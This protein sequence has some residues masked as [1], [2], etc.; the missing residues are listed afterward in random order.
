MTP[1]DSKTRES[2]VVSLVRGLGAA[3]KSRALYPDKH[4]QVQTPLHRV[5]DDLAV[6]FGGDR[7]ELALAISDG[8]LVFEGVP[9]FTLTSSVEALMDR[10]QKIEA[11]IVIFQRGLGA[12]DLEGFIRFLHESKSG[13]EGGGGAQAVLEASGVRYIRV[14]P[15]E[16][17][18]DDDLEAARELYDGAVD[19][20]KS[21]LSEV[22]SGRIPSGAESERVVR[23]MSAH[24]KRNRDALMALSLLRDF[25]EYTYTHSVNVSI[26]SLALAEALRLSPEE[27][28]EVGVAGLLHDVGKTNL[29]IELIRKPG[30][31]TV[32]E[33]E[34]IKR[35]PSEGFVLLGKMPHIRPNSATIAREHHL[36]YDMTGY[37]H[38]GPGYLPHP[39][40]HIVAVADCYDALTTMRSYQSAKTPLQAVE[41]MGKL[42]GKALSPEMVA[43]LSKTLGAYPVGTMVRLDTMEIGVVT[44][45]KMADEDVKVAILYD[46]RGN[47]LPAPE[48]VDVGQFGGGRRILGTVSPLLY[49]HPLADALGISPNRP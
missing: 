2:L 11:P 47:A 6:F 45:S 1:L 14:R 39:F 41:I 20:V 32:S 23:E 3:L 49:H 13:I 5:T 8:T 29:A 12:G 21:V 4:P 38:N 43:T 34:E 37:P 44:G 40:S 16:E 28:M 24:L 30:P 26:I 36:R 46:R 17:V 19:A 15:A 7:A 9:L 27:K 35:H 25:D 31:L 48:T 33:F 22:R 18:D 42:T 10:L